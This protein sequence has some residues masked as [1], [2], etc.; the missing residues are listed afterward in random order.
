MITST[1]IA[2]HRQCLKMAQKSSTYLSFGEDIQ[3]LRA[4]RKEGEE[5]LRSFPQW[6]KQQGCTN[7]QR[8]KNCLR[9]DSNVNTV[10][11]RH[12]EINV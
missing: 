9:M 12:L 6:R 4:L 3:A 8:V 7:G 2:A 11:K 5:Q 10:W 1:A